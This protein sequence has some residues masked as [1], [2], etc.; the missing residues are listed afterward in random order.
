VIE[1]C[2]AGRWYNPPKHKVS[3]A[4]V[5]RL[6]G[7]IRFAGFELDVRA[8]ELRQPGDQDRAKII[9]LAEQP[10]LILTMLLERPGQV[11]TR[12]EIRRRLW[13]NDTIVEFE[14]SISAAMNR[15]RQALGDSAESPRYIETLARRGY[16]WMIPVEAVE[17]APSGPPA[18]VAPALTAPEPK[19]STA[20]LIGK[21]VPHY[22]VLGIV[23]TGGMG[24]VYKAEDLR[25][26]RLVALKFLP[27]E[28]ADSPQ[29]LERFEREARAASTLNHPNICTIHEV[30]EHEGKPFIV[31]E[32]LEGQTLRERLAASNLSAPGGPGSA[33][34]IEEFLTLGIQ[35]ADGLEA[36]HRKGI[37]HRDIKPANIFIT[38]TGQAKILD[39]G[40]AKLT[41]IASPRPPRIEATSSGSTQQPNGHD[42]RTAAFETGHLTRPDAMMGDGRVHVA[43]ADTRREGGCADRPLLLRPGLVRD[44]HRAA[45]VLRGHNGH[46]PRGDPEASAHPSDGPQSEPASQVRG[47][48]R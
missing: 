8:G 6:Q 2:Q 40:I 25:L 4:G 5:G 16:R 22:C 14:H 24:V 35:I 18:V 23:G 45:G 29:A 19:P 26:G 17:A 46:D 36:A 38:A 31:M 42:T 11:L 48:G 3:Y 21:T 32:L 7:L 30:E 47:N 9:R 13:P 28:V 27:E 33:L 34:R 37:I 43:R 1:A 39:F 44:G 15:L 41:A 10:F 20:G 12:E